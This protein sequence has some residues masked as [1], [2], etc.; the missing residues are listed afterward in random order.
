M[1]LSW[2]VRQVIWMAASVFIKGKF[3]MLNLGVEIYLELRKCYQKS[4]KTI[5]GRLSVFVKFVFIGYICQ[6]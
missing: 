4:I 6:T 2:F 3:V 1:M 5:S